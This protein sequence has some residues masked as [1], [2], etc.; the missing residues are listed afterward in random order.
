MAIDA[1]GSIWIAN[2]GNNS[3]TKLSSTGAA[4][5]NYTGGGLNAPG[6]LG[7]DGAG[8]IWLPNSGG[9]SISE[10][11]NLG[12]ALTPLTGF[13]GGGLGTPAAAAVDGSGNVWV[14]NASSNVVSEFVGVAAPVVTPLVVGV[15]NNTL[16]TRP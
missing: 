14:S 12:V 11:S 13:A 15:K 3:L 9:N 16:G 4:G 2:A 5:N 1:S 10:F 6:P 8:N 7:I